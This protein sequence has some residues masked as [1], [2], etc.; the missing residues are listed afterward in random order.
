MLIHTTYL[1]QEFKQQLAKIFGVGLDDL[2]DPVDITISSKK[3]G[4]KQLGHILIDAPKPTSANPGN[5]GAID[6]A[7]A[8]TETDPAKQPTTTIVSG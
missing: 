3:E 2:A 6:T 7:P 4:T 8:D 5:F 1:K